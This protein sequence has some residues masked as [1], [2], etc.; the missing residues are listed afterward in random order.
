[1][2]SPVD[3]KDIFPVGPAIQEGSGLLPLTI[4]PGQAQDV[5]LHFIWSGDPFAGLQVGGYRF[6][7][8]LR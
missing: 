3:P 7:I 4:Q 2:F 5:E 6:V 8:R 1:V